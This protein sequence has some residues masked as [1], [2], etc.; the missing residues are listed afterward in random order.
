MGKRGGVVSRAQDLGVELLEPDDVAEVL[1][2]PRKTAVA[3]CRR[4]DIPGA[5][6]VG[7]E[8][9]V[10][11]WGLQQM[12]EKPKEKLDDDLQA[13][14]H[15]VADHGEDQERPRVP[16]PGGNQGRSRK[17]ARRPSR[18]DKRKRGRASS[19]RAEILRRLSE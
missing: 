13:E 18:E 5:K 14:Q 10:P 9:R 6:K 1:K 7:R 15:Q 17:A 8:W 2:I 4:G 3:L 11:A 12:F 16:D 19:R